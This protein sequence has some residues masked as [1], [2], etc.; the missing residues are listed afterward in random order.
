MQRSWWERGGVCVWALLAGLYADVLYPCVVLMRVMSRSHRSR[1]RR[2]GGP[3]LL[4]SF[5][6]S[7]AVG[8]VFVSLPVSPPWLAR[9][10]SACL[11]VCLLLLLLQC[12]K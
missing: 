12:Y 5:F 3:V 1:A 7:L 4:P 8:S 9:T 11:P 6:Q 10:L 2:N